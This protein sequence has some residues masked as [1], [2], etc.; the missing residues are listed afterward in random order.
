MVF[1]LSWARGFPSKNLVFSI[2]VDI[3][4][5]PS[6]EQS[7]Q[8]GLLTVCENLATCEK[9]QF[10]PL[11]CLVLLKLNSVGML[12]ITLLAAVIKSRCLSFVGLVYCFLG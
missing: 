11:L 1:H 2:F 6:Q 9:T 5:L 10:T 7:V 12:P 8:T 4:F 3:Y